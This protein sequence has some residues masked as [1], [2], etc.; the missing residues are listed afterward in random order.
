MRFQTGF[1]R[2]ALS[3]SQAG[4]GYGHD[5]HTL[6]AP[7]TTRFNAFNNSFSSTNM[8]VDRMGQVQVQDDDIIED[9]LEDEIMASIWPLSKRWNQTPPVSPTRFQFHLPPSSSTSNARSITTKVRSGSFKNCFAAPVHR[10][11]GTKFID[12]L[13]RWKGNRT[14]QST[15]V[16]TQLHSSILD[17]DSGG[18]CRSAGD[19]HRSAD[20]PTCGLIVSTSL[21]RRRQRR[22]HQ[23]QLSN[24]TTSSPSSS[25]LDS[26][27]IIR[28]L[29]LNSWNQPMKEKRLRRRKCSDLPSPPPCPPPTEK[30]PLPPMPPSIL[31]PRQPKALQYKQK[32]ARIDEIDQSLDDAVSCFPIPPLRIQSNNGCLASDFQF[33]RSSLSSSY[34]TAKD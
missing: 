24:S 26:P 25:I 32:E 8:I 21:Q 1:R 15:T 9:D 33:Q 31:T 5:H 19:I 4:E 7:P 13:L 3:S 11:Q 30:L 23:R 34:H 14:K 2:R 10:L 27:D 18:T 28:L 17:F 22:Q 16:S 20:A 29:D 12:G 6:F